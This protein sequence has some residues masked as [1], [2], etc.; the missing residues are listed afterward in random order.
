MAG[1]FYHGIQ[2]QL[3][4]DFRIWI[5]DE[6]YVGS[7]IEM[8][9]GGGV[10]IT[11]G[12][13]A[14]DPSAALIGSK[15]TFQFIINETDTDYQTLIDDLVGAEEGRFTLQLFEDTGSGYELYWAGKIL[16]DLIQVPD[17]YPS[18]VRLD[19]TDGIATLKDELYKVDDDTRYTGYDT[20]VEL[21]TKAFH[22]TGVIDPAYGNG[23]TDYSIRSHVKWFNDRMTGTSVD[24]LNVSRI[25]HSAF[26]LEG[27]ATSSPIFDLPTKNTEEVLE[28]IAS[29]WGAQVFQSAGRYWFLQTDERAQSSITAFD[30]A[31]AADG[32]RA[33]TIP[34]SSIDMRLLISQTAGIS[35]RLY[36]GQERYLAALNRVTS[37]YEHRGSTSIFQNPTDF[38]YATS[39]ISFPAAGGGLTLLG[40]LATEMTLDISML[41]DVK[42]TNNSE[43]NNT[44]QGI[45]WTNTNGLELQYVI[46]ISDGVTTYWLK[47]DVNGQP[48]WSS[49]AKLF[50]VNA[51]CPVVAANTN[52]ITGKA[53]HVL[54]VTSPPIPQPSKFYDQN[55]IQYSAR[56]VQFGNS[57]ISNAGFNVVAS[58][59]AQF[60]Q[61]KRESANDYELQF[62]L[63]NTSIVVKTDSND[64]IE[65]TNYVA[66]NTAAINTQPDLE[67]PDITFGGHVLGYNGGII[68]VTDGT[69][70]QIAE[71]TW[72]KNSV[73]G[74]DAFH[75]LRVDEAMN[76]RNENRKVYQGTIRSGVY[77]FYRSLLINGKLL[78][79]LGAT[80]DL[81]SDRWTGSW[82]ELERTGI[83][84]DPRPPFDS[85]RI[86]PEDSGWNLTDE[87]NRR[88]E[89]TLQG[90]NGIGKTSLQIE[91]GDTITSL[92]VYPLTTDA[93]KS[94][95]TITMYDVN[96]GRYQQ[97]T[98]GAD[99]TIGDASITISGS[100]TADFDYGAGSQL[101]ESIN[102]TVTGGNAIKLWSTF[103]ADSGSTTANTTADTLTV[104]G[105]T[106]ITTSISGD[107]LT[108]TNSSPTGD[109]NIWFEIVADSG[110]N[111]TPDT[112]TDALTFTGGTGIST[113]VDN[114]TD[115]VTIVNTSPN[116]SQNLWSTFTA[117]SGSTSANTTT[118]TLTVA[119]GTGISTEIVGDTLTIT[120]SGGS[121]SDSEVIDVYDN[122]GDQT[123]TSGTITLNLDTTRVS[124]TGWTLSADVITA[125]VAM[126]NVLFVY[127]VSTEVQTGSSRSVSYAWVER[128][129]GAGFT[130]VDGSRI[131]MYNRLAGAGD[132]TGTGQFVLSSVGIGDDFRIRVARLA[133]SDT[134]R[135][136]ADGSGISAY[137]LNGGEA[138]PT[139]PTAD[140]FLTFT[141]DTGSTTANSATDT[142]TVTGGAGVTTSISG[143]ILTIT[144]SG[145]SQT[146]DEV[147]TAGSTT[148]QTPTF[149]GNINLGQ[150]LY[151]S[152]DTNTY[153]RF[154]PDQIYLYAGGIN[155]IQMTEDTQD[156][157]RLGSG[158]TD[159]DVE[160]YD[161]TNRAKFGLDAGLSGGIIGGGLNDVES[162]KLLV[163][164]GL[165]YIGSITGQAGLLVNDA[166]GYVSTA[167]GIAD[168]ADV[169]MTDA[170]SGSVMMYANDTFYPAKTIDLDI[171][172]IY[173][174]GLT[175]WELTAGAAGTTITSPSYDE[176]EF[177][178]VNDVILFM[179]YISYTSRSGTLTN[180]VDIKTSFVLKNGQSATKLYGAKIGTFWTTAYHTGVTYAAGNLVVHS[181]ESSGIGGN[182]RLVLRMYKIDQSTPSQSQLVMTWSDL[183]STGGEIYMQGMVFDKD[184]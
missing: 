76:L 60:D 95:D 127:R 33:G 55:S 87:I 145:G 158:S 46:K 141:A 155:M 173:S 177:S 56:V 143:D 151:H 21:L 49:V 103:T 175:T 66:A 116:V 153:L 86:I 80:W 124:T 135:T 27:D 4:R 171:G 164:W 94:G 101:L 130:E 168:A 9:Q 167:G 128:D 62:R 41:I 184:V 40:T 2:T 89:T 137:N 39:S 10:Q 123:F 172:K 24:P 38:D 37:T 113:E 19:A 48:T 159:V 25:N 136:I 104:S 126:T 12:D 75:Q 98:V 5:Y 81:E 106:G 131:Y 69:G 20:F 165:K 152:G 107:T 156:I 6:D 170:E 34:T 22:K 54:K 111:A 16:I 138:G 148:A 178:T 50:K 31:I 119:G 53:S 118:D 150:Y 43:F 67:L 15:L 169:D 109:Q 61:D 57:A 157:I 99:T 117:D 23:S 45:T 183:L 36:L 93:L 58:G 17:T 120:G 77:D 72:A 26:Y 163:T 149:S 70:Y 121:G 110:T 179:G 100:P 79:P 52:P 133:G 47:R 162:G 91:E 88:I 132:Q 92:S 161:F 29:G 174:Q 102:D 182:Y 30:Y 32:T 114:T 59:G 176:M 139:G 166:D 51:T 125:N 18:V 11:Y 74:S 1:K 63:T 84:T 71:D 85:K 144:A 82:F 160:W 134:I 68:E 65:E 142:L 3:G 180:T 28:E 96:T 13:Q 7:G 154:T 73:A 147:L 35:R 8:R 97:L 122:T 112:T 140:T 129:T 146:L 90:V 181:I 14:K 105:G 42:I 64:N 108:I 78:A 44:G 83:L 115:T